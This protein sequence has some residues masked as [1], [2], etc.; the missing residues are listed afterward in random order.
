ML[1]S[2][3]GVRGDT[4]ARALRPSWRCRCR[5]RSRRRCRRFRGPTPSR[6]AAAR[7]LPEAGPQHLHPVD[8]ARR[9][10]LRS[11][12]ARNTVDVRICSSLAAGPQRPPRSQRSRSCRAQ[13]RRSTRCDCAR[14][15]RRR[16]HGQWSGRPRPRACLVD[17]RARVELAAERAAALPLPN[18][19]E[20]RSPPPQR[21]FTAPPHCTAEHLGM[22]GRASQNGND[23]SSNESLTRLHGHSSSHDRSHSAAFERNTSGRSDFFPCGNARC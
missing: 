5:S 9:V 20:S 19:L 8:K 1:V 21:P 10:Q 4:A 3:G 14:S 15:R 18:T 12:C 22:R 6:S 16:A 13:S 17:H 23:R 11:R 2:R 7:R